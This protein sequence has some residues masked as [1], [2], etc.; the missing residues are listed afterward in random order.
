[1]SSYTNGA[2]RYEIDGNGIIWTGMPD[3]PEP[4]TGLQ[5]LPIFAEHPQLENFRRIP[6]S[7][8]QEQMYYKGGFHSG[9]YRC[10]ICGQDHRFPP[11]KDFEIY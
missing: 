10:F 6:L 3:D 2:Y 5:D 7:K 8:L 11:K 1:M 9:T 4:Y